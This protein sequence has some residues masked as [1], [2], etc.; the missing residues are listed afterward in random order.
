MNVALDLAQHQVSLRLSWF[1]LA[2]DP[3]VGVPYKGSSRTSSGMDRNLAP[4]SR[5][6]K[7]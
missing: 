6:T 4:Q 7:E 5:R 3:L 1:S 2:L